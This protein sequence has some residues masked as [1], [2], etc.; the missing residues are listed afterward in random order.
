M[1]FVLI[2]SVVAGYI[3]VPSDKGGKSQ[4]LL[5]HMYMLIMRIP[6]TQITGCSKQLFTLIILFKDSNITYQSVCVWEIEAKNI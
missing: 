4:Y 3:L 6:L 2:G 1:T 5:I